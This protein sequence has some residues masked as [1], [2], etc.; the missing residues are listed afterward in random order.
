MSSTIQNNIKHEAKRD[1]LSPKQA[2]Q[3]LNLLVQ[4]LRSLGQNFNSVN[5]VNP[6][7]SCVGGSYTQHQHATSQLVN[8]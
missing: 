2:K 8:S 5:Q 4:H 7:S 1:Q 6:T 3:L